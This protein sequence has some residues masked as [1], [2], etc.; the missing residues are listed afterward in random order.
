MKYLATSAVIM[1]ILGVFLGIYCGSTIN[2]RIEYGIVFSFFG[3]IT[4]PLFAAMFNEI[5]NNGNIN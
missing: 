1:L 3:L 2:R 4:S 5:E